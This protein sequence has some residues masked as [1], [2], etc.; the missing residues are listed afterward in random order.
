[1]GGEDWNYFFGGNERRDTE[2]ERENKRVSQVRN[3]PTLQGII[4]R[5]AKSKDMV[6]KDGTA[7]IYEKGHGFFR[8]STYF[9]YNQTGNLD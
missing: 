3:D 6:P 4:G 2:T 5:I 8:I 9:L 1:M 7:A